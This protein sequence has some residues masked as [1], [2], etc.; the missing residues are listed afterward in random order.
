MRGAGYM[1]RRGERS[2]MHG[3]PKASLAGDRA[4]M[5]ELGTFV[6]T[7]RPW[8]VGPDRALLRQ[9]ASRVAARTAQQEIPKGKV[10]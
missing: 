1:H 8:I 3:E 7:C 5:I 2:N 6:K 10:A 9:G 4:V